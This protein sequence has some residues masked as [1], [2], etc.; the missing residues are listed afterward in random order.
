MIRR[1]LAIAAWL[2]AGAA[3]VGG[4]Y[5][6]FL[7]TPESNATTLTLS[8]ALMVAVVAVTALMVTGAV[9]TCHG[10]TLR[11]SL[12]AGRRGIPYF[13]IAIVPAL[14]LWW[15]VLLADAWTSR[16][17]GEISA[18]F[19]ARFGWADIE[20]LFTAATW[21]SRWLRYA[22][23]PVITVALLSAMLRDGLRGLR[24]AGW[25]RRIVRWRTLAVAT[26]VFIALFALP[27]QLTA[28][29]PGLPANWLQPT[30]AVIRLSI[31]ALA[32]ALGA[33]ALVAVASGLETYPDASLPPEA[34]SKAS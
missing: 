17:G 1:L 6:A 29:R 4:L 32:I 12:R 30:V 13:L 34:S 24:T 28:W 10:S 11:D 14:V 19:I 8:A 7:N 16:H 31:T 5:W 2:A 33:A 20:P 15:A 26:L 21:I 18:W 27:W 25:L 22:V 3:L 9:L 23:A